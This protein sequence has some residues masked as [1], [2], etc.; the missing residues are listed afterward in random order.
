MRRSF[1]SAVQVRTKEDAVV[2]QPLQEPER[3]GSPFLF[4]RVKK[5]LA[6]EPSSKRSSTIG[7]VGGGP[8]NRVRHETRGRAAAINR[9]VQEAT[10]PI[11]CVLHADTLL[12]DDAVAVMRRVLADPGTAL[13]GFTPLL[14]GPDR[15]RWGTSFHNWI[16]TW[17]APLLFRPQLFLR[18][19]RLLF[20][21][22]AMFFRRADFLA[23]G[24]CDPTLLVMEE[25]DLCIRFHRLGRTRLVN[26]VVIT[27]DRRVAAWGALRANWIYLKVGAR[28]GLGFRKGLERHYPDVR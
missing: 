5:L 22:H 2:D 15:V 14:S 25:A 13:A 7:A 1:N 24:G 9:G 3:C 4:D 12:P 11:I 20:G 19:V 10:A 8:T 18:G 27:S 6:G 28:W 16:K 26:R 21:D 23:V 17:Y